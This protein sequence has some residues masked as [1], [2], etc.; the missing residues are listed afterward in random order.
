MQLERY[1]MTQSEIKAYPKI[2][3]VIRTSN[4]LTSSALSLIY[5]LKHSHTKQVNDYISP[6]DW[7]QN[8][9]M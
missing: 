4:A 1:S 6:V 9:L 7:L 2:Q 8:K 3:I 5:G